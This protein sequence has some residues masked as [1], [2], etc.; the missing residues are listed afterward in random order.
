MLTYVL[1]M[2]NFDH[3]DK[4]DDSGDRINKEKPWCQLWTILHYPLHVAILLTLEGSA[5]FML[6]RNANEASTFLVNELLNA[7]DIADNGVELFQ[8]LNFIN[9]F[10]L[11]IDILPSPP[12]FK[13][14]NASPISLLCGSWEL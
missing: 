6:W 2:L 1:W 8:T 11:A 4:V 5:S 10:P 3:T 12:R 7:Y 9:F 13:A 14:M